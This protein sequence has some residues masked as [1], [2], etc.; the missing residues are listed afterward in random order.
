MAYHGPDL[1]PWVTAYDHSQDRWLGRRVVGRSRIVADNHGPPS[2]IMD[3]DGYLHVFFGTHGDNPIQYTRS[4]NPRGIDNWTGQRALPISNGTYP[5]PA[6]VNG[7]IYLFS[8]ISPGTG[9]REAYIYSSDNGDTWSD[10][11]VIIEYGDDGIYHTGLFVDGP[12]IHIPFGTN[13]SGSGLDNRTDVFHI[14]LDTSDHTVNTMD[15]ESHGSTISQPDVDDHAKIHDTGDNMA[16]IPRAVVRNGNPLIVFNEATD[17]D[18]QGTWEYRYVE[19]TGSG[20]SSPSTIVQNSSSSTEDHF[21]GPAVQLNDDGTIDAYLSVETGNDNRTEI[22][23]WKYNGSWTYVETPLPADLSDEYPIQSPTVPLNAH[24][25]FRVAASEVERGVYDNN[26]RGYAWGDSGI[27]QRREATDTHNVTADSVE[28]GGVVAGGI[29]AATLRGEAVSADRGIFGNQ[30]EV[31]NLGSRVGMSED[32]SFDKDDFET[33]IFDDVSEDAFDEYDE[34]TGEY[35]TSRSGMYLITGQATFDGVVDGERC[36]VRV[37][38]ESPDGTTRDLCRGVM[39]VSS[40]SA[41]VSVPV[42]IPNRAYQGWTVWM[43]VIVDNT[44]GGTATL[45]GD[46]WETYLNLTFLG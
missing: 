32:Y 23:R 39:P 6:I 18:R 9:R 13:D 7:D 46:N 4:Q 28:A 30:P 43:E 22:E 21:D 3:D 17:A 11:T 24:D 20:W 40:G 10:E 31:D 29:R 26:K 37:R 19:W 16:I 35:T 25:D 27:V 38:R 33:V 5:K 12:D 34:A 44:D 2:M 45:K 42:T 8:R 1:D 36:V 15:G 41:R 14:V